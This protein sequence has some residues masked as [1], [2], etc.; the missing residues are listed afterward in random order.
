MYLRTEFER[1]IMSNKKS[2]V[3]FGNVT[4]NVSVNQAK[5][6][7]NQAGGDIEPLPILNESEGVPYF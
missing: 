1:Q 7:I 3:N 2:D 6:D 5:G 4:G